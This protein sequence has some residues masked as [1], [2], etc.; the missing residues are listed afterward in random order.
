MSTFSPDEF[1]RQAIRVQDRL[2]QVQDARSECPYIDSLT[3]RMP[4]HYPIDRLSGEDIDALLAGGFRRSGT[5]LYYTRCA[6][7]HACEPTRV[8]VSTF[9]LSGS[10]KRVLRR[11]ERDLTL[12]W[13]SPIVDDERVALYNAHRSGRGLDTSPPIDASNYHAF[14]TDSCMPT[15]EL[16]IRKDEQLIGVSIMDIGDTGISAVYTHFDPT[17]ARYSPGTLAVLKQ[18]QWAAEH[19]R[20]WA[21]LGLYVR[22]NP[23]LNY[24]SRFTPQQRLI[25][26]QWRDIDA[27]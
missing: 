20:R 21:Y 6:P 4:L 25:A 2:L 7:C 3:A 1:P 16:E 22:S 24:K 26:G 18:I 10:F 5:L 23:H 27:S 15:L 9:H 14:L 13:Q 19:R 17:S 8:E 11:A 12:S